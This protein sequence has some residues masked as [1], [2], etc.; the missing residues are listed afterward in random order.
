MS[1]SGSSKETFFS[2]LEE[3]GVGSGGG[4]LW[5]QLKLQG[6]VLL[7]SSSFGGGI[8]SCSMSAAG[9]T[10]ASLSYRSFS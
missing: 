4:S 1:C 2:F 5:Q 7:M 9:L 3:E 8:R 6:M 10:V